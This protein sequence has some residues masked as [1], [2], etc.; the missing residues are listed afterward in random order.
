MCLYCKINMQLSKQ[1]S[2]ASNTKLRL[3]VLVQEWEGLRNN[4]CYLN[5]V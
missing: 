2:F 1:K 5:A 3:A 4:A